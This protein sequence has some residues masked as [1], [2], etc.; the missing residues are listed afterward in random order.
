MV[1]TPDGSQN[2]TVVLQILALKSNFISGIQ[3]KALLL[4]QY[5]PMFSGFD[6]LLLTI[7]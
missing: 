4:L 3:P 2:V 6:Q 1:A 5:L 7:F